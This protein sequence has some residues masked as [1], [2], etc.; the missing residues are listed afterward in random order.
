[1][2][3]LIKKN[4]IKDSTR[5]QLKL[6]CQFYVHVR[7]DSS[8]CLDKI[9]NYLSQKNAENHNLF[10]ELKKHDVPPRILIDQRICQNCNS[11]S[12]EDEIENLMIAI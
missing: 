10:I 5:H 1:M 4:I 2:L 11:N 9:K 7:P 12:V 3:S 6:I 8:D